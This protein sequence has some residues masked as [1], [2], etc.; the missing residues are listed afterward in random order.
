MRFTNNISEKEAKRDDSVVNC[1]VF[2]NRFY[3]GVDRI[4]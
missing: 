3:S 1:F 4:M 2:D